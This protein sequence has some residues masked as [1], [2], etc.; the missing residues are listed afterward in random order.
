MLKAAILTISDSCAEG[1]RED[2]S[3][4][5]IQEILVEGSYEICGY[6]V[7]ADDRDAIK[8]ALCEF[9]DQIKVDVILTTGGTGLGPRDV[10]PEAT[11]EVCDRLIPGIAE[12]IRA[13]GLKKTNNAMLSRA[14]AG[15]RGNTVIVNLPGSPKAVKESLAVILDVLPHAKDMI[16][17]RGH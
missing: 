14:I 6:Q 16:G 11:A 8:E 15:I 17:G 13:K 3:G 5:T 2:L 10:T 4:K 1:K 7:I 12:A 9:V